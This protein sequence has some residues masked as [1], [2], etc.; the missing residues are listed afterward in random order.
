M[1]KLRVVTIHEFEKND[2]A[3]TKTSTVDADEDEGNKG[4]SQDEMKIKKEIQTSCRET[5]EEWTFWM[6]KFT[7]H[8]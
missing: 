5:L 3:K 1:E 2:G 8:A 4:L 7:K 6:K